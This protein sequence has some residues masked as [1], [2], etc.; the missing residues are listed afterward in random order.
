MAQLKSARILL[1]D[2]HD[3]FTHNIAALLSTCLE[4]STCLGQ[5]SPSSS[6]AIVSYSAFEPQI[7]DG[8]SHILISPGPM[9]PQDYPKHRA[10]I[11]HCLE[12][13]KP[14]LG[15][16]LG[17]QSI[18]VYFGAQLLRLRTVA[19]GLRSPVQNPLK[20]K[21]RFQLSAATRQLWQGL[22]QEFQVGR[23]HSWALAADSIQAPLQIISYSVDD[24]QVMAIA[25]A[26]MPIWGIQF[27]PESFL[28]PE[29]ATLLH[30]FLQIP[31]SG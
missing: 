10:V 28:S 31:S 25:H 12:Q 24:K 9:T 20:P 19:H 22:P 6:Y 29:G 7:L 21:P 11:S 15:I 16:C 17:H 26:Q 4:Q 13:S 30:G 3:S 1:I 27:H 2:N 18:G 8:Y 5:F 23:Y 14:L